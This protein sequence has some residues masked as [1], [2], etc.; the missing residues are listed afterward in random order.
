VA[1]TFLRLEEELNLDLRNVESGTPCQA[2]S[3]I[4][5]RIQSYRHSRIIWSIPLDLGS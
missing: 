5:L 3:V 4:P 1:P 2:S